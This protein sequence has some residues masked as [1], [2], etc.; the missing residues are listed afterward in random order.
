MMNHFDR[1]RTA[2]LVIDYQNYGVHP[3]GYWAKRLPEVATQLAASGAVENTARVVAAARSKGLRVIHVG[4]AWREGSPDMNVSAPGLA[5]YRDRSIEGSWGAGFYA[6]LKPDAGE[7]IIWKRG[8]SALS[9]TELDRLLRLY[10]INTVVLGGVVTN[11]AIEATAF[12]AFDRGYR[13]VVL[14]DCCLSVTDL[15]HEHSIK[16]VLSQIATVIT[17]DEFIQSLMD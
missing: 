13:V 12:E 11:F 5:S 9:G 10:D 15:E 2:L 1:M 3:E 6:P 8:I 4:T 7:I 17:A 16:Y 14:R